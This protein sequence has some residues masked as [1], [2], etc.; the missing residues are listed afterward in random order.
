VLFR[1][2]PD[3]A[4]WGLKLLDAQA[5][6][7]QAEADE[8]DAKGALDVLRTISQPGEK[9][10]VAVPGLDYEIRFTMKWGRKSPDMALIA[11]DYKRADARPPMKR[12]EPTVAVSLI[13]KR[14]D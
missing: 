9:E 14:E 12:G 4:A 8:E 10:Y 5:R 7:K 6:K 13:N 3:A 2:D 1:D 11:M